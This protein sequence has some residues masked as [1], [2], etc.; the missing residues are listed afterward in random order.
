MPAGL[1]RVAVEFVSES[2]VS[3]W[4]VSGTCV[5]ADPR[6]SPDP[7]DESLGVAAARA[8]EHSLMYA[9]ISTPTA[10]AKP[11]LSPSTAATTPNPASPYAIVTRT[12]PPMKGKWRILPKEIEHET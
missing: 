3:H 9:S 12:I 8:S 1:S 4:S 11:M 7:S 2:P 6:A 5:G 10:I